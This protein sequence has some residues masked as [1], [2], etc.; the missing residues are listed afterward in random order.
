MVALI[1]INF[2]KLRVV[3]ESGISSGSTQDRITVLESAD[4]AG[5][6]VDFLSSDQAHYVVFNSTVVPLAL[7][8]ISHNC[9]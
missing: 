6:R 9:R 3:L 7:I 2:C 1:L 8:G 4:H 5:L